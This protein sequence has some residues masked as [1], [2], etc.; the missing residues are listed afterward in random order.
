MS[1]AVIFIFI[2]LL[3]GLVHRV[4]SLNNHSHPFKESALFWVVEY[5]SLFK[6]SLLVVSFIVLHKLKFYY[7]LTDTLNEFTKS[8]ICISSGSVDFIPSGDKVQITLLIDGKPV[9]LTMSIGNFYDLLKR[10]YDNIQKLQGGPY[11]S[12]LKQSS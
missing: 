1:C 5:A 9:A 3:I 10:E 11:F 6:W 7:M 12:T 2:L 4:R 8:G